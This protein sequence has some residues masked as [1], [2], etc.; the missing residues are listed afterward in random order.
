MKSKKLLFILNLLFIGLNFNCLFAMH[1]HMAEN[2][3]NI[4][5]FWQKY[6]ERE[7]FYLE[8]KKAF[9]SRNIEQFKSI[10]IKNRVKEISVYEYMSR[11]TVNDRAELIK[12]IL[13]FGD[14]YVIDQK[15]FF[16]LLSNLE[17]GDKKEARLLDARLKNKS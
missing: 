1:V 8:V 6:G 9:E 4:T 10:L 2:I 13:F 5:S 3:G 17:K 12:F 16:N 15:N 11:Y 14:K 7:N